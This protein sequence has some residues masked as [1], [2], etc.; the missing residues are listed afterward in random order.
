MIKFAE[1][2]PREQVRDILEAQRRSDLFHRE[3]RKLEVREEKKQKKHECSLLGERWNVPELGRRR[4]LCPE[5]DS[6]D[7]ELDRIGG[8]WACTHCGAVADELYNG[9]Y[10]WHTIQ[11]ARQSSPYNT[12]YH[13]NEIWAAYRG[14]G[15]VV[16][17]DDMLRIRHYIATTYVRDYT[18]SGFREYDPEKDGFVVV[19]LMDPLR[20]QRPHYVQVCK[21]VGLVSLGE[22]WVQIKKTLCGDRWQINYPSA[23]EEQAIQA[24]FARFCHGFNRLLYVT[25]KRRTVKDNMFNNGSGALARHNLPHYSWIIQQICHMLDP[26]M[27][28]RYQLDLFFPRPKTPIVRKRLVFTWLLICR[29][30][31]WELSLL[32]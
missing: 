11:R 24:A 12:I 19:A 5:C 17:E 31:D 10:E 13:F 29:H 30:L 20:M 25:G 4:L 14:R 8:L 18:A 2:L 28:E 32:E 26:G 23:A 15:P 9:P 21:R 1:P 3:L 7:V 16:L 6:A 27:R 22:R